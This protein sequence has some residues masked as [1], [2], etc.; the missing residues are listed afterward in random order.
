MR[1]ECLDQMLVLV[2]RTAANSFGLCG[3]SL[4]DLALTRAPLG[5]AVQ[6]S[7]VIV[8]IPILS[9][10]TTITSGYNFRK[11]IEGR[12]NGG[13]AHFATCALGRDRA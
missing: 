1:R 13:L 7:G 3:V 12:A 4:P 5:Q 9:G 11:G 8:A 2:R 10:C 6:R